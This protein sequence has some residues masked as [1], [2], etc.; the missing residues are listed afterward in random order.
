LTQDELPHLADERN[1]LTDEARLTL[2]GKLTRRGIGLEQIQNYRAE[3]IAIRQ[4]KELE[5]RP[6]LHRGIGTKFYGKSNYSHD[7]RCRIEEFDTTL[8]FVVIFF[9][10]I[11][12]AS[13]RIRRSFRSRWNIL[14]SDSFHVLRRLPRNWEQ[15]LATWIKA[16]A[17]LL[18]L[19]FLIPWSLEYLRTHGH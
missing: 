16:M 8:W 14:A 18:F 13:Y 19:R 3:T 4:A 1:E 5:V 2:E 11:P 12:I 17:V 15:I 6:R 7:V 9:P 10:L